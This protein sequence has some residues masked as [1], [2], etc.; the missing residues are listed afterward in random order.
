MEKTAKAIANIDSTHMIFY[1]PVVL[2][3][4]GIPT[5]LPG[6]AGDRVGMSFHNYWPKNFSLPIQNALSHSR[7][8]KDALFMTEF[9]ASVD[10]APVVEVAKLADSSLLP[11]IYWAYANKTPFKIVSP[12]LPATPEQQGVVLDLLKAREGANVN[13]PLLQALAR[14]YPIAIAG[15][16]ITFGFDPATQIFRLEYLTSGV[17]STLRSQE[18]VI[19]LPMSLYPKGYRVEAS[20]AK[21]T[22]SKGAKFLQLIAED[23]KNKVTLSVSPIR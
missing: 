19:V 6:L 9:G 17:D 23:E 18:T 3:G 2:F 5:N 16:P 7:K 15:R 10:R 14:P 11:W 20:G 1:E 12:G 8:T 4:F 13:R 21:V 22:S